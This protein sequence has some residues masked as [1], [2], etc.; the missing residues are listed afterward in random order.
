[1]YILER[2]RHVVGGCGD[3]ILE[4][5]RM[6]EN[7]GESLIFIYSRLFSVAFWQVL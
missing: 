6:H 2:I 7:Q 1:M 4:V 5:L 3:S